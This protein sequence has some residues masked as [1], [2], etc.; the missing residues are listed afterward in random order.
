[1]NRLQGIMK[2]HFRDKWTWLF[3]PAIVLFSSF[4][5]NLII[6]FFMDEPIYTGGI[7]SLFIYMLVSGIISLSQSFPFAL[8]LSIRRIDYFWGT[9]AVASLISALMAVLILLL[10]LV[11][12]STGAWGVD[13][14]YFH[15]PYLNDGTIAEQIIIYFAALLLFFFLGFFISSIYRRFGMA[16]LLTFGLFFLLLSTVCAFVFTYNQWWSAIFHW[17]AQHTAFQLALWSIP[18]T[19]IFASLSYL[20][21]RRSTV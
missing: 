16:G 18:A 13:V 12:T 21:L 19:V 15:L 1:M 5:T 11:E 2:M 7:I 4:L 17:I 14:H 8:G 9:V 3:I 10:S 20:L 6:G